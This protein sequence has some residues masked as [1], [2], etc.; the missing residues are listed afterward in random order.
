MDRIIKYKYYIGAFLIVI[1]GIVFIG[2][3][4]EEGVVD[5]KKLKSVELVSVRDLSLDNT[6]L[7]ITG[8]VSSQSQSDL[9]AEV[10]GKITAVYKK[11]GDYVYT[12]QII[13]EIENQTQR[14]ALLQAQGALD[15]AKASLDK[16]QGG[17]REEDLQVLSETFTNAENILNE[18][19]TSTINYLNSGFASFDGVI[20]G[21]VDGFFSNATG[22]NPQLNIPA[23]SGQ[24]K[25]DL[26]SSRA[27]LQDTYNVW[28]ESIDKYSKDSNLLSDIDKANSYLSELRDFLDKL[29][30]SVNNLSGSASLSQTTIDG[31]KT[32][33]SVARTT[34]ISAISTLSSAKD[35]LNTKISSYNIAETNLGKGQKGLQTEDLES[36]SASYTQALGAYK[37]AEAN[38][39]KTI[40]RSSI[41]GEIS[42][43]DIKSGDFVSA[44]LEIGQVSNDKALEIDSYISSSDLGQVSKLSKVLIDGRY[45][46]S[47]KDIA[48]ATDNTGK[49]KVNINL[50]EDNPNLVNGQSVKVSI[51]RDLDGL[52]IE[53]ISVPINSLKVGSDKSVVF[54]V[55]EQNK[56]ISH[57]VITGSIVGDKIIIKSGI[58]ED[59]MIVKDARGLKEGQEINIK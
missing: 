43:L 53:E 11:A 36:F 59:M 20:K 13:A 28:S 33:V 31:Y 15:V 2:D 24:N 10:P 6:P 48:T 42:R 3:E 4:K 18:S 26:E 16:A 30:L 58:T 47:V 8:R 17:T 46:G 7:E 19:K 54:T 56:L 51:S 37:V 14:A 34:T 25:I 44:Y 32:S 27:R 9:R 40:I 23:V 52:A 1:L 45:K 5:D 39:E 50:D 29:A 21:T 55:D 12:G 22:I 38:L 41:N 57:D 35:S 49:I